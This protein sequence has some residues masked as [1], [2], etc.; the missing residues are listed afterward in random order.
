M[1]D[2]KNSK[3]GSPED[4]A[5]S[6]RAQLDR[7]IEMARLNRNFKS[8]YSKLICRPLGGAQRS[9][10]YSTSASSPKSLSRDGNVLTI[11]IEKHLVE[12]ECK[13][14][15]LLTDFYKKQLETASELRGKEAE[16][17]L[18]QG[19]VIVEGC[20]TYVLLNSYLIAMEVSRRFRNSFTV[21]VTSQTINS[22]Q[23]K[24][25]EL[26][27]SRALRG[28]LITKMGEAPKIE[29]R[30]NAATLKKLEG[31]LGD[32]KQAERK[33]IEAKDEPAAEIQSYNY[34]A[35][36]RN[37]HTPLPH[38]DSSKVNDPSQ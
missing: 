13:L 26:E 21:K 28:A 8:N 22:T 19:K 32:I 38:L 2:P 10:S 17:A 34:T 24:E 33:L 7:S 4:S 29:T 31:I 1:R 20:K 12:L 9:R 30:K 3:W 23:L 6:C 36:N 11:A 27:V 37:L 15:P 18:L 14:S 25:L 35:Y 5:S 16:V